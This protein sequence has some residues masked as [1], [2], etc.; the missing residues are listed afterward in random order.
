MA[1][2]GCALS[3]AR[4]RGENLRYEWTDGK[5]VVVYESE[6]SAK[7]KVL[8]KGGSYKIKRG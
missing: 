5:N 1:C 8:R 7:A 6:M 2:G 4:R 3:A